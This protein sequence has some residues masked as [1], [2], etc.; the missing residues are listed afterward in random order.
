MEIDS[1]YNRQ[2]AIISIATAKTCII[3]IADLH[4][5]QALAIQ[6]ETERWDIYPQQNFCQ[7]KR[8]ANGNVRF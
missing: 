2:D 8:N 1:Q 3:M 7:K 5:H 6:N 4:Y